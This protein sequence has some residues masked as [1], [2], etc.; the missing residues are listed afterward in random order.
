MGS[1]VKGLLSFD[2]GCVVG[3]D[4]SIQMLNKSDSFM[5]GLWLSHNRKNEERSKKL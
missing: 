2:A 4:G 5:L 3:D 1:V